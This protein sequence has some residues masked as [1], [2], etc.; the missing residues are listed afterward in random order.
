MWSQLATGAATLSAKSKDFWVAVNGPS[1]GPN[2]IDWD[3]A[4]AVWDPIRKAGGRIFGYI[5]TCQP[6]IVIKDAA[7]QRVDD[8]WLFRDL[9]A[10]AAEVDT[11]VAGY[12]ALDGIWLD[13]FYPRYEMFDAMPDPDPNDPSQ[14]RP[15]SFRQTN[16]CYLPRDTGYLRAADNVYLPGH[17]I[18]PSDGFYATLTGWIKDHY[19]Q[20]LLIIGNAGGTLFTNQFHY[21]S[22]VDLLVGVEREYRIAVQGGFV[23][24]VA[25]ANPYQSALIHTAVSG[26]PNVPGQ[27]GIG[28]AR[29]PWLSAG[30][31]RT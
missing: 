5:H 12:P 14:P 8:Y 10:L 18:D 2:G 4:R 15:P 31:A 13:E 21:G 24:A 29:A 1:N 16:H 17:P 23:N 6:E 3:K 7:G 20:K 11:W 26:D 22:L 25:Q 9:E 27:W 28:S 19:D 30:H